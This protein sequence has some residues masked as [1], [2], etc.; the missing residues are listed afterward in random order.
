M[1]QTDVEIQE[2]TRLCILNILYKTK[3]YKTFGW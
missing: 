2:K 3:L 1:I